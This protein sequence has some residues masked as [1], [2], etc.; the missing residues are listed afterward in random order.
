M[1]L[2]AAAPPPGRCGDAPVCYDAR[3]FARLR[4]QPIADHPYAHALRAGDCYEG[5]K[6]RIS[7]ELNQQFLFALEDYRP[8]YL[9][10]AGQ[11]AVVHPV[12]LLHMSARTRSPSFRLAPDTGSV[13]AKDRVTFLLPAFVDE[14]LDV[15]WRIRDV[16]E[17]NGRLYQALDT[18]VSNARGEP[19]LRRDAHSV[20]FTRSGAPLAT[21]EPPSIHD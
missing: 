12:L 13:F 5:L 20:F 7:A 1:T 19:V 2:A 14:W 11:P 18:A 9:G 21:P 16:Y 3:L 8:D 17:R 6:F 4:M 15:A 10:A